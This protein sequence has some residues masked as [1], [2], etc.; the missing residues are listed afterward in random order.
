MYVVVVLV[1]YVYRFFVLFGFYIVIKK[2]VHLSYL[3]CSIV[4][5]LWE[6]RGSVRDQ[7]YEVYIYNFLQFSGYVLL[8]KQHAAKRK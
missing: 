6:D 7:M 1:L 2:L 8:F 3:C 4:S 5:R